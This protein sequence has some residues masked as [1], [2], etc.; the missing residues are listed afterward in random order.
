[1]VLYVRPKAIL[2]FSIRA[3]SRLTLAGS[4]LCIALLLLLIV[5]VTHSGWLP[6]MVEWGPSKPKLHAQYHYAV[7]YWIWCTILRCFLYLSC[8]FI[9][10]T[11][12]LVPLGGWSLYTLYQGFSNCRVRLPYQ[13]TWKKNKIK[14]IKSHLC[15]S[16]TQTHC[17]H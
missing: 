13:A 15:A 17:S 7:Y 4:L 5:V 10:K 14:K 1:M 12:A 3:D 6:S 11:C 8:K 9:L 16:K 2:L